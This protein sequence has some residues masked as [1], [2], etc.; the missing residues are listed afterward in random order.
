MSKTVNIV[1]LGCSKNLVDS[2][3]LLSQ[4]KLNGFEVMHDSDSL[5]DI[6]LINTCGF[7]QDAK[8]EAIE[9]I[10]QYTE[11]KQSGDVS[12]VYVFGCFPVRYMESLQ[13]EL[14]EVDKFFGKFELKNMLAEFGK[15]IVEEEINNREITTPN[16]YAYLK[17]S[18]GCNRFCAFCAIPIMSGRHTS[19][20]IEQL[21]DETQKL[22]DKGVKELL[23]IAQDLSSYGLDIYKEKKLAELVQ[24]IS[25]VDGIEWIKLH[26]AYPADF[27]TDILKVMK[28]N[29]KV[30]KYLDIAFQHNSDNMLSAMQRRISKQEQLDL[31]TKIREEV[32]GI[33][34]RTTL[35]T[36]FPNESE[37]DFKELIDF[38]K[39]QKF[40]RLGCFAFSNEEDT[41]AFKNFEDNIDQFIKEDRRDFIVNLQEKIIDTISR[42][43]LGKEFKVIVDRKEDG[44]YVARTEFDS[45]EIDG[46]VYIKDKNLEIGEFYN[47][48]VYDY[49]GYDLYAK[50]ID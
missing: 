40:E 25:K 39:K 22:A 32:P 5:S 38:V 34:L 50:I 24:E 19:K 29:P 20:P 7:I 21:V 11:L 17:I 36:G 6:V 31:I 41:Y 3:V 4:L 27:P 33:H 47:V 42:K 2:E 30:C 8:E 37:Q 48:E 43:K 12:K 14:P 13:K 10:L 49:M 45:P 35:L 44:L 46:E 18:E 15:E 23:V 28:E 1:T 16:H 9:K 26:Y